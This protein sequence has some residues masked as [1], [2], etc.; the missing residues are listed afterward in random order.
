MFGLQIKGPKVP[1]DTFAAGATSPDTAGGDTIKQMAADA[2]NAVSHLSAQAN[3]DIDNC[4]ST[5]AM[6][7]WQTPGCLAL[8]VHGK[9]SYLCHIMPPLCTC[10][11]LHQVVA[12]PL[13]YT[14]A[15]RQP[16]PLTLLQIGQNSDQLSKAGDILSGTGGGNYGK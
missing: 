1:N 4:R 13:L 2:S 9:D 14:L 15:N 6:W 8:H 11:V 7:S 16:G 10:S 12:R 3:I 5:T